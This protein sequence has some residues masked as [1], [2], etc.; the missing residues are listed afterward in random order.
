MGG[1]APTANQYVRS[2][3]RHDPE[4]R[5]AAPGLAARASLREP[6][7][8][9]AAPRAHSGRSH[10]DGGA[11]D[12]PTKSGPH[13]VGDDHEVRLDPLARRERDAGVPAVALDAAHRG[14][15]PDRVAAECLHQRTLQV[16]PVN[17]KQ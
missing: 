15:E 8:R 5:P 1:S 3:Q 16:T 4:A 17:G 13:T 9:D 7:W 2:G 10:G 12:G 6:Q 11:G 14:T